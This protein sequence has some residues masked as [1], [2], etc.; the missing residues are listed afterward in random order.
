L[1]AVSLRGSVSATRV[2]L[3]S[4]GLVAVKP[5]SAPL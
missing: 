4:G 1:I 3:A 5:C 2:V